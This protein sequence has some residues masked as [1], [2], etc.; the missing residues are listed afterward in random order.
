[1]TELDAHHADLNAK[2]LRDGFICFPWHSDTY[3][4]AQIAYN[5]GLLAMN[6]PTKADWRCGNT[7]FVGVGAL[8]NDREGRCPDKSGNA[9][10][11][12]TGPA[13]DFL[14]WSGLHP[15]S[16]H[17]AQLSVIKPGYPMPS[18]TEVVSAYVFRKNRDAAHVDGLLPEGPERRRKIREP[19]AFVLGLPLN[20]TNAGASP[21]VVWQGSHE[22][23]RTAF[24]RAL[25]PY[26]PKDWSD[27]DVTTAYKV[28]RRIVFDECPRTILHAEPGQAYLMHRLTV[29]GVAPWQ[30][31]STCPAEGRMISYFRPETKGG[32][33]DWLTAP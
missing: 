11:A 21:M 6:D 18:A 4:W 30:E 27:V 33:Q 24:T 31:G 13:L 1:L 10:P 8:G 25:A 17:L 22:V 16:W 23:M 12:L 15:A 2:F 20:L 32:V 29:H 9:G 26:A 14:Y 19:H 28:A 3:A 5:A 7:W